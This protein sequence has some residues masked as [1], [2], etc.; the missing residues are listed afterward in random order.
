MGRGRLARLSHGVMRAEAAL[1]ASLTA[2]IF[3]L[4]LASALMRFLQQPLIQADELAVHLMVCLAFLGA[5]LA[6]AQ[7]SHMT[8]ALLP[9]TLPPRAALW[10]QLATDLAVLSFLLI[11]ALVIWNWLDLPGLIRAGSASAYEAAS[12]NF[13]YSDPTQTLGLRKIWFWLVMPLTTL[14]SVLH[15]LA[16]LGADIAALRSRS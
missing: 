1:A 3:A 14:T 8:I 7:K 15:I 6:V 9:E 11:M 13:L 12:F 5:S 16:Q 2:L 10:L 4:M